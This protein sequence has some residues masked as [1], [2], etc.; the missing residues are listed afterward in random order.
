M[1]LGAAGVHLPGRMLATTAKRPVPQSLWLAASC[2]DAS[3]LERAARVG[4]DFAVL[5]PVAPTTSHPGSEPLGWKL[6]EDLVNE[7]QLSI[8]ALGG[9]QPEH[10]PTARAHGGRGVASIRATWSAHARYARGRRPSGFE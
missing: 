3:Q 8:Y 6:F 5:S 9:I 10:G 2:H 4:C 7:S 1:E